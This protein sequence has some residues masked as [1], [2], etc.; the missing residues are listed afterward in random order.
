MLQPQ[1]QACGT[2]FEF[3]MLNQDFST[4]EVKIEHIQATL[5]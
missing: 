2:V 1:K 5:N 3:C 4:C